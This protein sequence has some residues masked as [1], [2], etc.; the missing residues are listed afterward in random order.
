M[1][2]LKPQAILGI[3]CALLALTGLTIFF[4]LWQWHHDWQLTHQPISSTIAAD[5]ADKTTQIIAA[6]PSQHL[7][8][9][10]LGNTPAAYA[11]LRV[12]GIV[13]KENEQGDNH[14]KVYISTAG[15]PSKL[16]KVGDTLPSGSK[17]YE[18]TATA[19]ILEQDGQLEKLPLPRKSLQFK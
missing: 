11:Q 6:I 17:I 18:I 4:M 3:N 8:G 16:Y 1:I 2:L 5:N 10:P 15:Q 14:S 13:K 12:T 9:K 7:F 19:V